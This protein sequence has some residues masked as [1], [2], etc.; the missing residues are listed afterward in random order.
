MKLFHCHALDTAGAE[1]CMPFGRE[2]LEHH[3]ARGSCIIS[4][5]DTSSYSLSVIGNKI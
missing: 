1:G 4:I 3:L 5:I 2:V